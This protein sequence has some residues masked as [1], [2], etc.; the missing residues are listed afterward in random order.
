M[1]TKKL[2]IVALI[3]AIAGGATLQAAIPAAQR[4]ALIA[5]YTATNG[6]SWTTRTGWKDGT[7]EPDGFGPIGTEN[8]WFGVHTNA[9]NTYVDYIAL[10]SNHLVGTIPSSLSDLTNLASLSLSNNQLTGS[11]PASLGSLTALVTLSLS[12]NQLSGPIPSELGSLTNL[13]YLY[14]D[15]NG[16]LNGS[17]PTSLGSLTNLQY[18]HLG[19][20]ALTGSIPTQLGNLTNL[21]SLRMGA[22]QLSGGIPTELGNLTNLTVLWLHQ[23]QLTGSIP[24]QLGSL[25]NLTYL[26]LNSNHLSGAIPS[27]LGNLTALTNLR[28]YGNILEGPIPT[29]LTSLT[30]LSASGTDIGY[31][32]LYTSDGALIT[33]LNSK[34]ADWAA[35]QTIAPTGVTATALDGAAIRV[36]WT[37]IP[38]TAGTGY[39]AVYQSTTEGG[40]YSTFA[41]QTANKTATSFDVEGLTPD[42]RY[43]F[44]V[45][46]HT[47]PYAYNLNAV[48]S[49][50]SAEASAIARTQINCRITG[51]ILLGGTTPVENVV[52]SG[53]DGDP[54]TDASGVYDVTVPAG[55]SGTVTPTL[56]GHTFSPVS[57]SYEDVT[58]DQL[59]QDYTAT[60]VNYT[61]SGTVT[62]G[63]GLANVAMDGL[64]G[65]PL[66]DGSGF[67]TATVSYGFS[68]TVTPTL[69]GYNFTPTNRVYSSVGS[70]QLDQDYSAAL[71][72][73]TLTVIAVNG[74]VTKDPD[75]AT[76]THGSTVTLTPTPDAHYRFVGWS[77]DASGADDPLVVTMDAN[78]TIMAEFALVTYTISGT[79]TLG[80]GGLAGVVLS[81]LPGDPTTD[82]SGSYT[83]TVDYG[84][85]GTATPTKPG[86]TF[87][88]P[89]RSYADVAADQTA[90]DYTASNIPYTL[91]VGGIDGSVTK[92]P[93]QAT[94]N[95]GDSV[96]LTAVPDTGYHFVE[97][98]GDATGSVNPLTV[99]MDG[100]KS[101]TATFAINTYT[102]SGTITSGG[103][104]LAGVVMTGL[105]GSPTTNA[106]GLYTV[107]VDHGFAATVT[108]TLAGYAFTPVS[109]E[110]TSVDEDKLSQDYTAV[111]AIPPAQRAALIA[112]Y[113][114]TAGDAWTSN[115][116]WK[117]EPL[118]ADGFALRG[119][120]YTW[121]GVATNALHTYVTGLAIANN[122]LVGTIP[123]S[124]SDLTNL[125]TLS[126]SGNTLSG[127]IPTSLGSLTGLTIL[128]LHTNALTGSIPSELG[129]L[130]NLLT[131]RL[132]GNQ[133]NGSIPT[134]LGDLVNLTDLNLSHNQ[135][136]GSIPG[137][138]GGL[139]NLLS[140]RVD[141]NQLTGTIPTQLGDLS[142]LQVLMLQRNQLS[143]AIPDSLGNLT[144]LSWLQL[145]TNQLDGVIPSTLSNLT[146]LI[147]LN[148]AGN[149]LSGEIPTS[150]T[151]LT[152]LST[153]ATDIGYNALHTSDADLITF[154]N[155]KDP[156]WAAT[157][158]IPPSNVSATPL[159]GGNILISWTPIAY[160]GN[161]GFYRVLSSETEGGPYTQAAVTANKSATNALISGLTPGG[162]YYFVVQTHTDAHTANLNAVDSEYSAEVNEMAWLQVNVRITGTILFEESP[163]ANVVMSG[164]P[165]DPTTN[166]SGIYDVTM[167]AGFSGTVTPTL[168]GYT[169]TPP[170]RTYSSVQT[171]LIN[172]D[173]SAALATYTLTYT[174]G[175]NGSITGTTPQTVDYGTSGTAVTAVPDTGYHFVDW[176]DASTDNPRTDTN[177]TAN[178]SVT[179]NFAINTYTLT[180][181]AGANGS[182]TGTTPQTVDYGASGTA[183]TAVPDTG[184]HFVNWSDASTDNPRTDTNVTADV[185][186]TANFAI[187]TFTLTY[188]AGSNGSITGTTPQT[189]DY[190]A[191]GTA[192]TAVPDTGYHFVDWSDGSTDNPRTDT[193]VTADVSVTANF[194]IDTFTLTYAAGTN[195]SITG[196]TP[197]TVD[198]GAS[199]TAV[200]AVRYDG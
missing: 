83:A 15:L 152:N 194:A 123:A 78:K 1:K 100:N 42:Q 98:T 5:L 70:D 200:T 164:L 33:F 148:L 74:T 86:F 57:M 121:A 20:N 129:S 110:Y 36:S 103:T 9:G 124:L 113:N 54:M 3:L 73:Y 11:I 151:S 174:A 157:Q 25:T 60:L 4:A 187:D 106:S 12:N 147:Y 181:A 80:G 182:I 136:S 55:W 90:Q 109:I 13:V 141:I 43:Y 51:T 134:Q 91:T 47:D 117:D 44:I 145:Y 59:G 162:R 53:F 22:N 116:H 62:A 8:T 30:N 79:V 65:T 107:T 165:G 77:G 19:T 170:S 191:S 82:G 163:L 150:L 115:L 168:T 155:A 26:Y 81:G 21:R 29:S 190:S 184:Y 105:P 176:S 49:H 169:F 63:G 75:Q 179:A 104:G 76:Y 28:L 135:L 114:A 180:Y 188:S 39:Y 128:S 111:R 14:L 138:L 64:P 197:Q 171:D 178:I 198:Y 7:L 23:N 67:Y 24:T 89:S 27:S 146:N 144:Q 69:T 35:T 149:K 112:L 126:L 193:N 132:D 118:E 6:D 92:S 37:A 125:A 72:E 160:T 61:I 161:T 189:V 31:N 183:V 97:W 159:D 196:T 186:V 45:R 120:E 94:Y 156:N 177:V 85:D 143:G 131:L 101:I 56:T 130:T 192:V 38:F 66:T 175:A 185:S 10:T 40:P 133:L 137:E 41:G 154:L 173:Y 16:G 2:A 68:A 167:P 95:Y 199:G 153:S 139:S 102:I 46:T 158:T 17:I 48:D 52:M 99:I 34:D 166:A 122:H 108:P 93:D 84:F 172:Q 71:N 96:D 140:F 32:A 195:G 18:L 50:N 87:D 142:N 58:E 119:T 127:S 88:P